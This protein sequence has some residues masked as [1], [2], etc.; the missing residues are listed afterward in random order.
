MNE[1]R[2][3]KK[4]A[5]EVHVPQNISLRQMPPLQGSTEVWQ[6]RGQS[7]MASIC[8]MSVYNR[9]LHLHACQVFRGPDHMIPCYGGEAQRP[10]LK[11][12]IL[13]RTR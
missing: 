8:Q 7:V 10:R 5:F 9:G 2:R 11:T 13:Y 3:F 4:G 6:R 1:Q 12:E